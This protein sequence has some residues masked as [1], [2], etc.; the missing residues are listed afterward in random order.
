[1]NCPKS[2]PKIIKKGVH[3]LLRDLSDNSDE[4]DV[5]DRNHNTPDNPEQPWLRHFYEYINAVEQVPDGWSAIKWWGISL[6]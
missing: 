4:D 1:M 2:S 5:T 6:C 3:V